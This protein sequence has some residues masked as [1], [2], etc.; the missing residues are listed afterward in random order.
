VVVQVQAEVL[1]FLGKVLVVVVVQ[2]QDKVLEVVVV[3]PALLLKRVVE[4]IMEV[5]ALMAEL[6]QSALFGQEIHDNSL[7]PVLQINKDNQ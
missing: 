3:L 2:L 7:Q 5:A 4:V 6:E 1:V